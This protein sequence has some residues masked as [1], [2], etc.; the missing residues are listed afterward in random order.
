MV[1]SSRSKVTSSKVSKV[2]SKAL[3]SKSTSKTTKTLA[4][5][6]L[7]QSKSHKK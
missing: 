4:G 3:K 5:S 1:K 2:A 7:A 6:A